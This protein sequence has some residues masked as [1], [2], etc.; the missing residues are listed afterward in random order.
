MIV[1][2]QRR[3]SQLRG[4]QSDLDTRRL[5]R[6]VKSRPGG[7]TGCRFSGGVRGRAVTNLRLSA[8]LQFPLRRPR[9]AASE[10]MFGRVETLALLDQQKAPASLQ[11]YA[12]PD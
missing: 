12:N 2:Y 7:V 1:I 8:V 11:L 4:Y 10:R 5:D 9:A 3:Q 6:L